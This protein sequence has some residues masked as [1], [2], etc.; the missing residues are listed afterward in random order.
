MNLAYLGCSFRHFAVKDLE[1][2]Y[3]SKQDLSDFYRAIH[4]TLNLNGLCIL[5]TCNRVE[6][7]FETTTPESTSSELIKHIAAFKN[8]PIETVKN[9]LNY[10]EKQNALEHLFKVSCGIKSM[11]FGENEILGQVKTAYVNFTTN[12][13]NSPLLNKVFQ[14]AIATGK[15]TRSETQISQ[16]AY[17]ISSIAIEAIR[18]RCLD[19]FAQDILII[20]AGIIAERLIKK[21]DALGHPSISICN[22]SQNKADTLAKTYNLQCITLNTIKEKLHK[23]R[24][25]F[26][27][28]SAKE[29]LLND[30]DLN[31]NTPPHIP[32]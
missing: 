28:T 14:S 18:E 29:F 26:T 24:I 12:Q 10:K 23:Y 21:F 22:R 3:I 30:V 4:T 13:Q 8:L 32:N 15:R 27:A 31:Q 11:V 19:Y 1:K 20:G 6:F 16:G 2:L 17:S 5:M 9:M 25:I 7:Y